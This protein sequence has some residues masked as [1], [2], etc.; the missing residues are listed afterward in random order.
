MSSPKSQIVQVKL[1]QRRSLIAGYSLAKSKSK[2]WLVFLSESGSMFMHGHR[3]GINSLVGTRIADRF[4]FLVINKPGQFAK[5]VN[6]KIYE[7][8]FRRAKRIEDAVA[9]LKAVI[10]K[11]HHTHLVGYSEGA[12]LAPQIALR[13]KRTKTVSM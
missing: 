1:K 7:Q 2:H 3:H 9:A 4:N 6:R 13:D 8:S 5:K 12:Y 10:P 11:N